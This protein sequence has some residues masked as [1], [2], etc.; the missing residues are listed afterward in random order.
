LLGKKPGD[1]A[2]R[3][4]FGDNSDQP[5]AI[6]DRPSSVNPLHKSQPV[7]RFAAEATPDRTTSRAVVEHLWNAVQSPEASSSGTADPP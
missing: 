2:L 7:H 3:H 5:I 6:L 4:W 1:P